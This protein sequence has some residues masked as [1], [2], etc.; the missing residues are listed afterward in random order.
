MSWED[1]LGNMKTLDLWRR[2]IG[3]SYEEEA[4]DAKRPP[5]NRRAPRPIDGH[6]MRYSR[7]Q[8]LDKDISQLVM[9]CDNQTTMPHAAVMFDDFIEKGGELPCR[10]AGLLRTEGKEYVVKDG[11]V[12]EFL[13]NV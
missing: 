10:E 2:E 1:T 11:D 3:L 9:G 7:I 5:I 6:N 13:F 8:G 4:I 12:I